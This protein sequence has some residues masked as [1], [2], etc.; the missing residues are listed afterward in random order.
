MQV[1]PQT[2]SLMSTYIKEIKKIPKLSHE[3]LRKYGEKALSGDIDARNALVRSHLGLAIKVAKKYR[4]TG[5]PLIDLV[6]EGNIG[7]MQAASRFNPDKG[8]S[9]AAYAV[10]WIQQAIRQAIYSKGQMIRIPAHWRKES[11]RM[12]SAIEDSH[13]RGGTKH[14]IDEIKGETSPKQIHVFKPTQISWKVVSLNVSVND[15]KTQLCEIIENKRSP[16]SEHE[17]FSQSLADDINKVLSTLNAQESEIISR[18]YGL[19]GH[20]PQTLAEIGNEYS[21]TRERIRQIENR[22]LLKLKNPLRTR[23]FESYRN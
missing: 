20:I 17:M 10:W 7:L 9:F 3:N 11:S 16:T 4:C 18:R 12:K 1:T 13:A 21:L 19:N 14:S 5:L 8:N 6:S 22:A 2:D 15:Q 23:Y